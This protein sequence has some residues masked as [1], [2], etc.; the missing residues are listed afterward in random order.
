GE[1]GLRDAAQESGVKVKRLERHVG[2]VLVGHTWSWSVFRVGS[3]LAYDALLLIHN[4]DLN[5]ALVS[6]RALLNVGRAWGDEPTTGAVWHRLSVYR[7]AL[8][9]IERALAQGEA[10]AA[11]LQAVQ[12]LLA[13]EE[14]QPVFL[15][16]LRGKRASL[17]RHLEGLHE[18]RI[19]SSAL[20]GT[21]RRGRELVA[22]PSEDEAV[23]LVS[24][25]LKSN[26][27]ALLKVHTDQ[28]EFAKLPLE[29]QE[30]PFR[31]QKNNMSPY[32]LV[33]RWTWGSEN[34]ATS[35]RFSWT[36]LRCM[37][38]ALALERYRCE[39]GCWPDTL[40]AL[41]PA[42]LTQ[43]PADPYDGKPLRYRPLPE[44]VLIYSV[45]P[46][47]LDNGGN[48]PDRRGARMGTDLGLRLWDVALRRQPV[49]N[50][51]VGPPRPAG[52]PPGPPRPRRSIFGEPLP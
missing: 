27:A 12:E 47:G 18:G 44:G 48:L 39:H 19:E 17:D 24:G 38:G 51:T 45:G 15:N 42:Q 40:S 31:L 37:I 35:L 7:L 14:G 8:E 16:V 34:L 6:C 28:V 1:P 23:F 10:S 9:R 4:R 22:P 43:V 49:R 20:L 30:A 3:L 29:E 26:R 21:P 5:R 41:V 25:S 52:L 46:D 2:S 50:S 32:S 36:Q 11:A 13:D 33:Q